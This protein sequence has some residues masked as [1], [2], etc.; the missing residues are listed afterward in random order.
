MQL[1]AERGGDLR[2]LQRGIGRVVAAVVEEVAD[3]VRAADVDQPLVVRAVL[4][5]RLELEAAGTKGAARRVRER[6]DVASRS[7]RVSISSSRSTPMIPLRAAYTRPMRFRVLACGLDHG[8]GRRV[9]RRGDATG[10]GVKQVPCAHA[11]LLV[12]LW[13]RRL[14]TK[15]GLLFKQTRCS[16]I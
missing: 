4:L 1:M 3:V 5:E 13:S 6:A 2:N 11:L 10:L 14:S 12:R 7:K 15:P 9:D 8:R 16:S